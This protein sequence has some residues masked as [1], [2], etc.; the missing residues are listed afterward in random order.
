PSNLEPILK[1]MQIETENWLE[2]V[3]Q[4]DNWFYRIAGRAK[5]FIE[6]AR[7]T[8]HKWLAGK[9]ASTKAFT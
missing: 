3:A 2:T 9:T 6:T 7:N 1:R 8:G 4:F 5:K